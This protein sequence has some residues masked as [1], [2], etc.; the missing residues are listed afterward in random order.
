MAKIELQKLD[1]RTDYAASEAYKRLRT[2]LQLCGADKKV[3]LA[4]STL[5]NEGK[6]TTTVNLA[7]SLTELDK[8]VLFIDADL[9][10]SVL[11]GRFH[12]HE[13]VRGLSHYLAGQA[14]MEQIINDTNVFGMDMVLAGPNLPNPS[15]MLS[16]EAFRGLIRYAR[17]VYDYVIIDAPP[18]ASVIDA[19]IIAPECD[20]TVMIIAAGEVNKKTALQVKQQLDKTGTPVLGAILNKVDASTDKYYG[21]YYGRY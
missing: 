14:E 8:K 6:S 2:N 21:K 1:E 17:E 9:R 16:K 20:G 5:P 19:V 15:E 7:I 11:A 13:A 4:T 3:I 18:V 12:L 10:K